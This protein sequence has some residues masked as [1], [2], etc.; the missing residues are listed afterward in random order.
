MAGWRRDQAADLRSDANGAMRFLRSNGH[1]QHRAARWDGR[2]RFNRRGRRG[3]QRMRGGSGDRVSAAGRRRPV[4][5]KQP[6]AKAISAGFR[7]GCFGS[8]SAAP[9]CQPPRRSSASMPRESARASRCGPWPENGTPQRPVNLFRDRTNPAIFLKT[10][11][12]A[13]YRFVNELRFVNGS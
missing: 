8:P 1:R 5:V 11:L 2:A 6:R 4:G 10:W 13:A 12:K 9:V 3:P 7:G